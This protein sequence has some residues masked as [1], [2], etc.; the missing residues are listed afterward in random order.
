M[1][2]IVGLVSLPDPCRIL[3]VSWIFVPVRVQIQGNSHLDFISLNFNLNDVA[4]V[5]EDTYFVVS[6]IF[7]TDTSSYCLLIIH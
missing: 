2:V 5:S 3:H 1:V 7:K 6:D 4:I